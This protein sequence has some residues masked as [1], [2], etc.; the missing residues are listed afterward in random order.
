MSVLSSALSNFSL[1]KLSFSLLLGDSRVGCAG[2]LGTGRIVTSGKA[3]RGRKGKGAC[4]AGTVF[5]LDPA[6][7][8]VAGALFL[9]G[10]M[11]VGGVGSFPFP[12]PRAVVPRG[13]SVNLPLPFAN[14]MARKKGCPPLTKILSR[15]GSRCGDS[16]VPEFEGCVKVEGRS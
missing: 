12:R 4:F 16:N 8:D 9:E 10:C 2:G 14:D 13:G 6:E 15:V 5:V 11:R 3:Y 1:A 7:L